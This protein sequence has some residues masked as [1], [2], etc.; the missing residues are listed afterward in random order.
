MRKSITLVDCAAGVVLVLKNLPMQEIKETTGSNPWIRKIPWRR[1]W[2]HTPVFLPGESHEQ[3]S[4][5]GYSP[6]GR[7]ESGTITAA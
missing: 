6:W 5:E 1:K 3:R 4:P 7:K 2:Q